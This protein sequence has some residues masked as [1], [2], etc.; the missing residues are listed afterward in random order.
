MAAEARSK[1]AARKNVFSKHDRYTG[2][3]LIRKHGDSYT[4]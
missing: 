4:P 1:V 2:N 3:L